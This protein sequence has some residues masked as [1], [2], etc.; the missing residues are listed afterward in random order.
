MVIDARRGQFYVTPYE[1]RGGQWVQIADHRS[2]DPASAAAML[3]PEM[4]LV[5]EGAKAFLDATKGKWSVA[6]EDAAIPRARFAAL[7][8]YERFRSGAPDELLTV[9]PLYL[10]PTEAEETWKR[11]HSQA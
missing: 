7:L 8:G 1:A 4:V 6:P 5:G 11:K 3:S 2:L 9:E 10:R